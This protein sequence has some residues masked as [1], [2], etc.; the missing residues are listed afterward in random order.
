[1]DQPGDEFL[2]ATKVGTNRDVIWNEIGA[3]VQGFGG[4]CDECGEVS[5]DHVPLQWLH[6]EMAAKQQ[7]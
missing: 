4:D 3:V 7:A 6:D 2:E 5:D 1:V